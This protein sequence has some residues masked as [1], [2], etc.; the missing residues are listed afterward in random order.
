MD[1]ETL[2]TNFS[3]FAVLQSTGVSRTLKYFFTYGDS[4]TSR[5]GH[6]KK[7]IFTELCYLL[8]VDIFYYTLKKSVIN[9]VTRKVLNTRKLS[10]L[11]CQLLRILIFT[12]KFLSSI[13]NTVNYFPQSDELTS[14]TRKHPPNTQV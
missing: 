5:I 1:S 6:L 14:F 7:N 9:V 2:L 10:N 4:E 11:R 12:L 13:T 8:N 3:Y